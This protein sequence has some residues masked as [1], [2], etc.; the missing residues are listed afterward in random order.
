MKPILFLLLFLLFNSCRKEM[1]IEDKLSGKWELRTS[2]NGWTGATTT[3]SPGNG[4]IEEFTETTY[5]R[6]SNGQI[7]ETGTYAIVKDTIWGQLADR[8]IYNGFTGYPEFFI[9]LEGDRLSFYSKIIG[10]GGQYERIK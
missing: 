7:D 4:N 10:S 3:Y 1:T 8:I 2:G 5:T 6:Y 9:S